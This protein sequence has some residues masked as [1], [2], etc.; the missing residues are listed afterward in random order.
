[1]IIIAHRLSTVEK[2]DRIIVIDKGQ[3]R[4]QGT[5]M[6]LLKQGGMYSK[7]VSKTTACLRTPSQPNGAHDRQC[8]KLHTRS[9]RAQ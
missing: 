2:A 7:L 6:D 3:V 9:S 1:M 4:E 8:Q 5:H